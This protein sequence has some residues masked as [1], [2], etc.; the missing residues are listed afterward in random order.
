[1]VS[2]KDYCEKLMVH[3]KEK[4]TR[5]ER[6]DSYY[7]ISGYPSMGSSRQVS[8]YLEL[9]IRAQTH[10]SCVKLVVKS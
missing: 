3:K 9:G 7:K 5:E 8:E 10:A 6:P 1:V 2:E 4:K